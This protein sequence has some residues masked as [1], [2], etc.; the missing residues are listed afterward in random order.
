[1]Y[2][3][4]SIVGRLNPK[5]VPFF[6]LYDEMTRCILPSPYLP[7][8]GYLCFPHTIYNSVKIDT[9]SLVRTVCPEKRINAIFRGCEFTGGWVVPTAFVKL[10]ILE[11]DDGISG[12]VIYKKGSA[13][14]ES[15]SFITSR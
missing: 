14:F 9:G 2:S 3:L 1:M 5:L 11:L 12:Y 15:I 13:F 6:Q 7:I 8:T 10:N 4:C